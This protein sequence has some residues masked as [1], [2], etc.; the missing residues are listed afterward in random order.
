MY[1]TRAFANLTG[2]TEKALR[3]Y[4]RVGLLAPKRT[5]ARYRRYSL[6]DL[7]R[8]ER[9][10]ALKSLG[11][12]LQKIKT[13]LQGGGVPLRAHREAIEQKR[14][15]LDRAIEA[16]A[17]IEKH[18]RLAEALRVFMIEAAWERWE[19]ERKKRASTAPRAP[20]RA[21]ESRIALFREIE[22]ALAEDPAR[23]RA[24]TLA[25]RWHDTVDPETLA[26]LTRRAHWSDGMR[27]YMASL[28]ETTP[29][30]WEQVVGFVEAQ[31][32]R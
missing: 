31:G 22:S 12:P 32:T 17:H 7:R 25:A 11:L 16:L 3:H 5:G 27:R 20:D 19:A 1:S 26:A 14:A 9:I 15:R 23:G 24:K 2:V 18:S 28:Y 30:I 13:L 8:L 4:E 10:L 29:D 21:S 6:G